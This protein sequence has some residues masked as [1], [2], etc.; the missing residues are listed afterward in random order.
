MTVREYFK[1][2]YAKNAPEYLQGVLR[3]LGELPPEKEEEL[4]KEQIKIL[5]GVQEK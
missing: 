2:K 5:E 4:T 3:T 1:S